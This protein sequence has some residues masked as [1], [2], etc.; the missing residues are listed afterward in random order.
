[1][2]EVLADALS[3]QVLEPGTNDAGVHPSYIVKPGKFGIVDT[4]PPVGEIPI[5]DLGRLVSES[6]EERKTEL[7]KLRIA[8]S[9][10][11][12]FQVKENGLTSSRFYHK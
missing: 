11:G 2:A 8:L 1:M 3:K 5:I 4:S 10:W 7:D 12:C 6:L 9:D